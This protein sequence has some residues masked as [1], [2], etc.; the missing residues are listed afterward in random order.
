MRLLFIFTQGP[1]TSLH[2]TAGNES[3]DLDSMACALSHAHYLHSQL[4]SAEGGVVSLPLFQCTRADFAL[5]PAAAW[6][7]EERLSLDTTKM[8][9]LDDLSV[10]KLASVGKLSLTLV[11]HNSP[12]G[13]LKEF[14]HSIVEVIDHHQQTSEEGDWKS[15]LEK[16]GSCSTLVGE[17]LLADSTYA[18]EP[19]VA[20]LLLAAILLD[21]LNLAA[22]FGK[23]TDKD[24]EIAKKLRAIAEIVDQDDFY[25]ALSHKAFNVGHLTSVQLLRMDHK[26][27]QIGQLTIGFSSIKMLLSDFLLRENISADVHSFCS[28]SGLHAIVLLGISVSETGEKRRQIAISQL[29]GAVDVPPDLVDSLASVLEANE[30]LECEREGGEGGGAFDGIL[31]EQRNV[32]MSRKQILPLLADFLHTM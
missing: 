27:I 9:F 18:M 11:D 16:V 29:S 28:I 31:L 22:D 2:V 13:L 10:K 8:V 12:T 19:S 17:K 26:K 3:C 5:R 25:A 24:I 23:T 14:V 6:I 21:T 4:S 7:F 30:E 20:T 15:T 1:S 32:K